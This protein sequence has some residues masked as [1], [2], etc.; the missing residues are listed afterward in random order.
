M[1]SIK[2]IIKISFVFLFILL[3]SVPSTAFASRRVKAK[4]IIK[5]IN[6]GKNIFYENVTINGDLDF[7]EIKDTEREDLKIYRSYIN[8]SIIFINCEFEGKV[9]SYKKERGYIYKTMFQRNVSFKGSV[10]NKV[11]RFRNT[12]F[13][14]NANFR[15]VKFKSDVSFRGVQFLGKAVFK[16]TTFNKTVNFRNSIFSGSV[17]FDKADFNSKYQFAGATL[18]GKPIEPDNLDYIDDDDDD[19]DDDDDYDWDDNDDG[20]W[21]W[22]DDDDG[23]HYDDDNDGYSKTVNAS[24]IIDLIDRGDNVYFENAVI[25]GVLDFT[26]IKNTKRRGIYTEGE[27]TS[28]ITFRN[29]LFKSDII[30]SYSKKKTIFKKGVSFAGCVVRGEVDFNKCDFIEYADFSKAEFETNVDFSEIEFGSNAD[31][32][33]VKFKRNANFHESRFENDA[34]FSKSVFSQSADFSWA[35]FDEKADFSYVRFDGSVEFFGTSFFGE[36]VFTGTTKNGSKFNP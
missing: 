33:N 28:T 25:K 30:G 6:K 24:D 13:M 4:D 12:Q 34:N 14:G 22:D 3:I 31:F 2:T 1:K 20:E 29:C 8:S 11:V 26:K 7:T 21:Y 15:N 9:T 5:D 23:D 16:N 17:T 27:V 35:F 18:W 10:F 19:W 32:I 36:K